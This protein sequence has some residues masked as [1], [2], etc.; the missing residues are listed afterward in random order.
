[1]SVYPWQQTVWKK[2]MNQRQQGLFP[3]ALLCVG[4]SGLGKIDFAKHL[5]ITL[6]CDQKKENACGKCRSCQL[7]H[8]ENHP[9]FYVLSPEEKSQSIK[10]SQV[11]ELIGVLEQTAA[12]QNG[13]V[14]LI[15]PVER[16][17]RASSNALLK[18]LEEPHGDVVIILVANQFGVLPA[19]M[20]SRCQR[21][22]FTPPAV[23]SSLPWLIEQLPN[24]KMEIPFLLKISENAP[25]RAL[26]I[27]EKNYLALRDNMISDLEKL[28]SCETWVTQLAESWH[29]QELMMVLRIFLS[30]G[31]DIMRMG[32]AL[33]TEA[34][35]NSDRLVALQQFVKKIH[36]KK[37]TDW[38]SQL[39][40]IIEQLRIS[41]SI[42]VPLLLEGLLIRWQKLGKENVG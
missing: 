26:E 22:L 30:L 28:W 5:A 25:L 35:E 8:A 1:M 12:R 7:F 20:V 11:R 29:K 37:L 4:P 3:H 34:F 10:V 39:I 21:L 24:R 40:T 36:L 38:L 17:N 31:M 14:V 16:M 41:S 42:N 19:T 15:Y 2:L 18:T 9:D 6:L 32:L 23:E 13:Q 33:P 27:A